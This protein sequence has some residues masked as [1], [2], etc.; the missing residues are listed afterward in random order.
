MLKALQKGDTEQTRKIEDHLVAEASTDRED[1]EKLRE[2]LRAALLFRAQTDASEAGDEAG[3]ELFR[4]LMLAS[5][6]ERTVK[7]AIA[8]ALLHAG[9]QEGGLPAKSHDQMTALLEETEM[10]QEMRTLVTSVPRLR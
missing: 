4:Q 2:E 6:S 8:G 3:A 7:V 9:L 5:C 10:S 1:G